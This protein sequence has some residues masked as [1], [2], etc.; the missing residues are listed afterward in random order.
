MISQASAVFISNSEPAYFAACPRH[1]R[2]RAQKI[3]DQLELGIFVPEK[4]VSLEDALCP[5]DKLAI[6][7][8]DRGLYFSFPDAMYGCIEDLDHPLVKKLLRQYNRAHCLF[9]ELNRSRHYFALAL[10]RRGKLERRLAGDLARDI[11]IDEGKKQ[12]EEKMERAT[13]L[14]GYGENLVSAMMASFIGPPNKRILT[15]LQVEIFE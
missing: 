15:K 3:V 1:S 7:A 12:P 9:I 8:Y 10:L 4:V 2:S 5:D 14:Y 11:F 6:G 13:E